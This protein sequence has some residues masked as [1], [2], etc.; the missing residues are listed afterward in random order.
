[1]QKESHIFRL[2]TADGDTIKDTVITWKEYEHQNEL[3][4]IEGYY[5]NSL[6]HSEKVSAI[7]DNTDLK[8]KRRATQMFKTPE[9]N[10]PFPSKMK[11]CINN[12]RFNSKFGILSIE[13]LPTHDFKDSTK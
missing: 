13:L 10:K 6:S 11:W 9:K 3:S 12:K 7:V 8:L 4:M 2:Q 5:F 1:M